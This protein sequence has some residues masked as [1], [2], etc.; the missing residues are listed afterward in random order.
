MLMLTWVVT[1]FGQGYLSS[2]SSP[3]AEVTSSILHMGWMAV[4]VLNCLA[5]V[6]NVAASAKS[7]TAKVANRSDRGNKRVQKA[8]VN[9]VDMEVILAHIGLGVGALMHTISHTDQTLGKEEISYLFRDAWLDIV[10]VHPIVNWSVYALYKRRQH[11]QQNA[12]LLHWISQIFNALSCLTSFF[13]NY[14]T[15]TAPV[16]YIL[17]NAVGN[18]C[19]SLQIWWL[20]NDMVREATGQRSGTDSSLV[21]YTILCAIVAGIA[22]GN[23]DDFEW[24]WT[25]HTTPNLY[26]VNVVFL[27]Y[28][29]GQTTSFLGL[30]D[31]EFPRKHNARVC[32]GTNRISISK[33][34]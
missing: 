17:L 30:L 7:T 29:L 19:N 15:V 23:F 13:C 32:K 9:K 12:K 27:G 3:L 26:L 6:K 34:L 10:V 28:I 5:A 11:R 2:T 16:L 20:G 22:S 18:G 4:I 25:E 24:F 33:T 21:A 14:T 1:I 8:P 31:D